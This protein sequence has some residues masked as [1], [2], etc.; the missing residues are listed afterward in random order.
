MRSS[1]VIGVVLVFLGVVGALYGG[2][3]AYDGH[4]M[5]QISGFGDFACEALA[6]QPAKTFV[7]TPTG[8]AVE[9]V[10]VS[11]TANDGDLA[12]AARA[13][14]A[15]YRNQTLIGTA[16]AAFSILGLGVGVV[17]FLPGG[18]KRWTT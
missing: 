11:S 5:A 9:N 3:T 18:L 8:Y 2:Y 13:L 7:R 6:S 10:R 16:L 1:E 14:D 17:M 4:Q 15:K 12:Q